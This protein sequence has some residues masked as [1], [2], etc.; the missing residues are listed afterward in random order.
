MLIA[1]VAVLLAP[2]VLSQ[3]PP[4]HHGGHGGP[5]WAPVEMYNVITV[6]GASGSAVS[7]DITGTAVRGA[8]GKVV[9]MTPSTPRSGTYYFA[10][11]TAVI[12]FAGKGNRTM[13][14]KPVI[15]DYGNATINVSGASGVVTW[16]NITSTGHGRGN[17]VL[18]FTDVGVYLP[19]G[20]TASFRLST[21]AQ[22]KRSA[23]NSSMLIVGS[24]SLRSVL[25]G[26]LSAGAK[27]PA[28]AKPVMLKTVDGSK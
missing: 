25:Q 27:F 8:D 16:K 1:S 17:M 6:T 22:I 24:P 19:N 15:G 7:F 13:H 4:R 11:D 9:L 21:P 3:A 18:Q 5:G 14:Q 23:D 26:A 12:P 20:T 28:G 2:G 10:N